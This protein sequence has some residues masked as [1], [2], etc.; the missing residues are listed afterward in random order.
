MDI[1]HLSLQ[2]QDFLL[3]KRFSGAVGMHNLFEPLCSVPKSGPPVTAC[4]VLLTA[5]IFRRFPERPF[6]LPEH[7]QWMARL[8]ALL[9]K[10]L[11]GP[12]HLMTDR[13]GA[14][15]MRSIG[16]DQ[17]YD[18]IIDDLHDS[19]GLNQEKYWASGKL[20]ALSRLKAPCM[21]M[22]MDLAVWQPLAL[23]GLPLAAA[24]IEHLNERFYPDPRTFFE[25]SPRYAFPEDWNYAAE[26]L[27]TAVMYI[28]NE[29]LRQMYLKESFRFMQFERDTPD[30]GSNCMIF[31]EQ[32]ILAM[33]AARMGIQPTVLLD[34]DRLGDPQPLITHT[35]SGKHVMNSVSKLADAFSAC[36]RERCME[37]A[38]SCTAVIE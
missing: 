31:A 16:M 32:R 37:L 12:I 25:M 22:D 33:C 34:Y 4:H 28:G 8:S 13:V 9:W 14:A 17:V 27:N 36:C 15:Y 30:N 6:S 7:E 24:H 21:I 2:E 3:G 20:L 1:R 5:P 11:N 29:E 18:E 35:W 19:Y 23:Q 38:A 26:P 10:R